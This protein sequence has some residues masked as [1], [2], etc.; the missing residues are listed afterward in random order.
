MSKT[1]SAP[2]AVLWVLLGAQ[3]GLAQD[4]EI[5]AVGALG[6]D[7]RWVVG[8]N[9][10]GNGGLTPSPSAPSQ[11]RPAAGAPLGEAALRLSRGV[12]LS[13]GKAAA[14]P[15]PRA[16]SEGNGRNSEGDGNGQRRRALRSETD[17]PPARI[18]PCPAQGRRASAPAGGNWGAMW[19]ESMM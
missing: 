3:A 13:L 15:E 1:T 9:D 11:V 17:S 5:Q 19:Q 18:P 10:Q 4:Y 6:D 14:S 8:I 7:D 12:P 2:F 16:A